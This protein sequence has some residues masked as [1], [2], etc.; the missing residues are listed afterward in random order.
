MKKSLIA[1][2]VLI[3]LSVP[4]VGHAVDLTLRDAPASVYFSPD[5]GATE[6][7]VREID[8][9]TLDVR[10]QVVTSLTSAPIAKALVDAHKRGVSVEV[11]LDKSQRTEKYS[12][13]TFLANNR[14]PVYIER[15]CHRT[16]QDHDHRRTDGHHGVVQLHEGGRREERGEPPRHQVEGVGEDL[17][18]ELGEAQGAFGAVRAALLIAGYSALRVPRWI[19][20]Q[21]HGIFP[22]EGRSLPRPSVLVDEDD[23]LERPFEHGHHLGDLRP[24]E[25]RPACAPPAVKGATLIERPVETRA[26]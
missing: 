24:V 7:I 12:G 15:A 8:K 11:I 22:V 10:V 14:V 6:A 16:Q 13:A 26:S 25:Q 3:A 5:G 21:R 1:F 4:A 9:A 23:L 19:L 20:L 17:R 18:G 2:A